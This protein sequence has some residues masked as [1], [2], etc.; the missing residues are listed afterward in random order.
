ML[1]HASV[2]RTVCFVFIRTSM[3]ESGRANVLLSAPCLSRLMLK[4][5]HCWGC[6]TYGRMSHTFPVLCCVGRKEEK[7][8]YVLE[9]PYFPNF[10]CVVR[11]EFPF[12]LYSQFIDISL[13]L[14]VYSCHRTKCHVQDTFEK[15][16]TDLQYR[17]TGLND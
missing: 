16:Y 11:D 6:R 13:I 12:I 9:E 7:Y 5:G 1:L 8:D 4:Q 10:A 2:C 14:T 3:S 17:V 15:I